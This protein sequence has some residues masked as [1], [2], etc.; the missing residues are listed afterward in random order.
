MGDVEWVS[1]TTCL[2][3]INYVSPHKA[4]PELTK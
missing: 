3:G 1:N 4:K 2:K